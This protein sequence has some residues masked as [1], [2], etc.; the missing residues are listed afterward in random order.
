M[1]FFDA[2]GIPAVSAF[3]VVSN[4]AGGAQHTIHVTAAWSNHRWIKSPLAGVLT[5]DVAF[6][7][8]H[9]YTATVEVLPDGRAVSQN[10]AYSD[11]ARFRAMGMPEAALLIARR[12]LGVPI[13]SSSNRAS[14]WWLKSESHQ[15]EARKVWERLV[16]HGAESPPGDSDRWMLP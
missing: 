9:A 10:M 15:P 1:S 6:H 14:E 16:Q 5:L 4:G 8:E 12:V 2:D 3:D 11:R 13:F 7:G